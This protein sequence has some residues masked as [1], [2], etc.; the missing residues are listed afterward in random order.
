MTEISSSEWLKILSDIKPEIVEFSGGGEPYKHKEILPILSGIQSNW[1]ITSNTL[2]PKIMET[3]FSKCS[4]W[5]ASFHPHITEKGKMRFFNNLNFIAQKTNVSVTIV[6]TV[7]NLQESLRWANIINKMGRMVHIHPYYDDPMFSWYDHPDELSFLKR[8]KFVAYNEMML[9]FKGIEGEKECTAGKN[10]IV[11]APDGKKY[12]C[13]SDL[14]FQRSPMTDQ[15][16]N[17]FCPFPC[18]WT[19]GVK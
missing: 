5:T 7:N 8:S 15:K 6:S 4:F 2:H 19:L 10:F 14:M 13:M 3:D 16:C 9:S 12:N 1:A 11:I 18:D 17:S